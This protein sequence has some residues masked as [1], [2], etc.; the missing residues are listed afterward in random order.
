MPL[1][2]HQKAVLKRLKEKKTKITPKMAGEM[3]SQAYSSEELDQLKNLLAAQLAECIVNAND[4]S[5]QLHQTCFSS[6]VGVQE[7][8]GWSYSRS[9]NKPWARASFF[10]AEEKKLKDR[11]KE[12][13]NAEIQV[14]LGVERASSWYSSKPAPDAVYMQISGTSGV[15][16]SEWVKQKE[17]VRGWKR[18]LQ[19]QIKEAQS[20]LAEINLVV[21][22]E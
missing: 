22:D 21:P 11:F 9:I 19:F 6:K 16:L 1:D 18:Q 5:M 14:T 4:T 2:K 8:R 20:M 12:K 17:E 7:Y 10:K 13:F 3:L 15:V